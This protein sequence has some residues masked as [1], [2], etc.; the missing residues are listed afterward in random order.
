M[1]N[2]HLPHVKRRVE[3][4]SVDLTDHGDTIYYF[5]NAANFTQDKITDEGVFWGGIRWAFR[6][7]QSSNW[8]TGDAVERPKIV[9]PDPGAALCT[10]LRSLD[11]APGATVMR[12]QALGESVDAGHHLPIS[13][14]HY[15]LMNVASVPGIQVD[16]E[17]GTIFDYRKLKS[18]SFIMT[19]EDFPGLGSNLTR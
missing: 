17:L 16:L 1:T 18:P 4:V 7:F 5:C 9:I 10:K 6:P 12:Y 14:E 3:F 8:K 2:L 15:K 11:G 19:R 13:I